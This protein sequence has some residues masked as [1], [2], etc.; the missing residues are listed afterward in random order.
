MLKLLDA[1]RSNPALSYF[2]VHQNKSYTFNDILLKEPLYKDTQ[3]KTLIFL[4]LDNSISSISMF[5]SCYAL[6]KTLVLL[7]NQLNTTLKEQLEQ[8]YS[9]YYIFDFSRFTIKDYASISWGKIGLFVSTNFTESNIHPDIKILLSTSGTTGSPKFVK[10]SDE[11]L[12]Q[13]ALSIID[14]L[15]ID[16]NSVTP[17]N[18]PVHY[19]YGLSILTTNSIAG[20]QII[21][22]LT[23]I[24]SKSFWSDFERFGFTSIAGVPYTYE[25]LN[26]IGFTKNKHPSLNYLTQAGGKLSDKLIELFADYATHNNVLFYIMYGQT[27]ATARMAY[28]QPEMIKNKI[29]SIGKPIKNGKFSI[30]ANT[31][32]LLY[33]GPNV[34]GGY[35]QMASDLSVFEPFHELQTGDIAKVDEDGYFYIIGRIKRIIKIAGSRI[36]LDELETM[37]KNHFGGCTL[38]CF[39]Q[40]DK[41]IIIGFCDQTLKEDKIKDYL[42]DL[43]KLHPSFIKVNLLSDIPLTVNGKINYKQLTE[44]YGYL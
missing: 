18:L 44:L 3:D 36:N 39:G 35:A 19:S 24:L 23:D 32:E 9:P 33:S 22:S 43:L 41:S 28:L 11:N 6:N 21:C 40:D 14:Y 4:Y 12:Y 13:N 27:E 7:S 17:L 42:K 31:N 26:R 38:V 37:L 30:D 20:G 10:L 5:W 1:V 2:D 25:V 16:K 8:Q 29:G 15:P 34:F